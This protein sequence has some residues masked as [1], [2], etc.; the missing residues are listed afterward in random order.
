[1]PDVKMFLHDEQIQYRSPHLVNLKKS[2]DPWSAI[3]AVSPEQEE[4][5]L[6]AKFMREEARENFVIP[7][8]TVMPVLPEDKI[9]IKKQ[10]YLTQFSAAV[11][12]WHES[13]V[14]KKSLLRTERKMQKESAREQKQKTIIAKAESVVEKITVN[15]TRGQHI[16]KLAWRAAV[17]ALILIIPFKASSF[18]QSLKTTTGQIAGDGTEGFMALQ[19]STSAILNSD[20][21]GAQNSVVLALQKFDSAVET[22]NDNYKL[23]QKIAASVPIVANEV[24]SRQK[25]ITAGQKLALGN[26][27][28]IKGIGETKNNSDLSLTDRVK[29]LTEHLNAAIPNYKNALDDMAAV[30]ADVLP[31]EYQSAFK[32]FRVLFAAFLDDL[33]NL[34]DLGTAFNEIFG[35][36]GLR[37]YLIVFQN[38]SEIRPTGGFIGSFAVID[39]ENGKITNIDVPAGGSYDL[40]GQL[41]TSVE[42]PTPLLLSNKR[43]EFQDANWFPD[44]SAS[45]QKLLWFHRH[46]R[47]VTADGVIAVNATV[48]ERLLAIM[49]P[50]S[51]ASR[52]IKLS[53]STAVA[54]LQSEVES[55]EARSTGK[56]KQIIADLAP[57]FVNYIFNISPENI[58][59]LMTSLSDALEKKEIQ[60]YFTDANAETTMN[61]FGWSGKILSIEPTQDYLTVIDTNIQGQKSDAEISQTISHQAIIADDG[62]I[63]DTVVITRTHNGAAGEDLYGQANIDYLRIYVPEGAEL[64]SA[65]GFTWPDEKKF[66]APESWTSKDEFLL[67]AEKEIGFDAKSGTR[68]TDE[69]GKTAYGNWIIVQ[70]GETRQ[71]Q[72]TYKL[73]FKVVSEA[74]DQN[75][76]ILQKLVGADKITSR[77]QLVAQKQSGVDSEFES[78][79]IYPN[80][81]HPSWN[82]GEHSTLAANGLGIKKFILESDEVWSLLMTKENK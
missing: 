58:F 75:Q 74:A 36:Q 45:A 77:Y 54:T 73:P 42:P 80:N 16:F 28:L 40:Q 6:Y 9:T 34:S 2:S 20:L 8:I 21:T 22:M 5:N 60:A 48:L 81:W 66:R 37:R 10:S 55:D 3:E 1:M 52:S 69:F 25:I 27:Y 26:T 31:T 39:V 41:D 64:I 29:T 7:K 14:A 30:D 61:E 12:S 44:F 33:Q 15:A 56:P 19:D 68:I 47:Q 46:S 18:Y 38:P 43:W 72:F 67:N 50:V 49:G 57:Q 65:G 23:L 11:S 70:P 63:T 79:I 78:Q 59:S 51:D 53:S 76:N 35:G 13:R 62:S 4:N 71:V 24:E 32:D 17:F 82:D